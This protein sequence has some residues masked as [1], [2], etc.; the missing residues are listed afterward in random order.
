M[1]PSLAKILWLVCLVGLFG[2]IAIVLLRV[3]RSNEWRHAHIAQLVL[4]KH[5][6]LDL[7]AVGFWGDMMFNVFVI[8]FCLFK[9]SVPERLD[10]MLGAFNLTFAAPIVTKIIKGS[11]NGEPAVPEKPV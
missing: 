5:G 9:G 3:D 1:D 4:N 2:A 8:V 10:M 11:A 7:A 6:G